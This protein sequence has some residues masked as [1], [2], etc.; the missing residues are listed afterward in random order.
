MKPI[1]LDSTKEFFH[2]MG[3]IKLN[4]L[5]IEQAICPPTTIDPIA[6]FRFSSKT[7]KISLCNLNCPNHLHFLHP[8]CI[9][10]HLLSLL[11][12][13]CYLHSLTSRAIELLS[14]YCFLCDCLTYLRSRV[15][16]SKLDLYVQTQLSTSSDDALYFLPF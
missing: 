4:C 11:P 2:F 6:I 7:G 12:H 5:S 13:F 10:S 8:V 1:S 16:F 9:Q 15:K 14:L 3:L